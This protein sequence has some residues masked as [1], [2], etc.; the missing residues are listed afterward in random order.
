M[1]YQWSP[2][3]E[4]HLRL[5]RHQSLSP[6]GFTW[7]FGTTSVL[8]ALPLVTVLGSPVWWGL[9]PFIAAALYAIWFAIQR[10]RHDSNVTEVL[11]LQP[12]LIILD[13]RGPRQTHHHW[14]ANP[15]WVQ[16][17]V[18][19]T[20]G[21]VPHYLTLRGNGREVEIGAFLSED[22]RKSL[23]AEL[24]QKLRAVREGQTSPAGMQP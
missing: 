5:W 21:P 18:Y 10:N 23:S 3:P 16:L 4:P 22:E 6:G 19:P 9:L 14:E 1:P 13:R 11:D 2:S 24:H 8:I 15:H 20:E 17:R 7:F 12:D